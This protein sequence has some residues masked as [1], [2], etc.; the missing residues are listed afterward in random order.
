MVDVFVSYSSQDRERVSGLVAEIEAIG[1]SVWWD[2]AIGAGN[3]FDREIEKAIDEARCIIVV[4]SKHSIES[5][6]VRTEANEGLVRGNLVPVAIETVRPPL[7]FRMLQTIDIA[8]PDANASLVSA[9]A[10]LLPAPSAGEG[11][12]CVGRARELER[13]GAALDRAKRGEG[14][15]LL[16]SGEAGIGKTRMTAE[17]ERLA[18]SGEVLVLRGHCSDAEGAPPYQPLLEQIERLARLIGPEAM[19]QRLGENATELSKLMPELNQRYADIPPYPSLPP[20]QE[21]RYLLHGVAEFVARGAAAGRAGLLG[22]RG[23]SV[24][25]RGGAGAPS[26]DR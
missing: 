25:H 15:L 22:D 8:A 26:R 7:A 13:I 6:W 14:S 12:P 4:W 16:F 24:L 17:A 11:L 1:Y 5:E 9:I 18:R 19:R 21:R 20:E 2:R 10:K 23:Q 3:A